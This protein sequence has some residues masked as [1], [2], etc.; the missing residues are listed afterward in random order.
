MCGV[1]GGVD[2][3][4]GCGEVWVP[5]FTGGG[6]AGVRQL[7]MFSYSGMLVTDCF[8]SSLKYTR[9]GQRRA[10]VCLYSNRLRVRRHKRGAILRPNRYTFVEQSG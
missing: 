6:G 9:R 3:A 4:A 5:V 8:A 7:G 1:V 2:F 10:L